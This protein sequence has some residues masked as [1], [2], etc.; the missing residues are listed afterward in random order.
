[1]NNE[2]IIVLIVLLVV[3]VNIIW[4]RAKMFIRSNGLKAN[5]FWSH[6]RD[7]YSL[8]SL[9]KDKYPREVRVKAIMYLIYLS[10]M[11]FIVLIIGG[12]LR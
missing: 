10:G 3:A 4:Y 11:I 8:Y 1:M 2:F 9:S 7:F 6:F 5:W 12:V